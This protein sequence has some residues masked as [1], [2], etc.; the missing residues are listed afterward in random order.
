M[1]NNA[2]MKRRIVFA[3][4]SPDDYLSLTV[5]RC[6]YLLDLT[7]PTPEEN[8]ALEEA[9]LEWGEQ[10][11]AECLRL[12][13]SPVHFVVMGAG[14]PMKTDVNIAECER[15]GIPILRRCSGGG[16]V[17]QGP[18][19]FNY[20]L[21]LDREARGELGTIKS[22]NEE[23]LG[24][25]AEAL[26][27]CGVPGAKVQGTSDLTAGDLKFSGNSQR[28]RKRYLLF[29]GTVLYDFE[30]GMVSECL[31]SP[32]KMPEYREGRE[33]GRF[34]TNIPVDAERAKAEIAKVWGAA[35][36]LKDWPRERTEELARGR[37]ADQEWIRSI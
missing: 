15:R 6:M 26:S 24:K 16:T 18:G 30:L 31:G 36:V 8:L 32:E 22:S 37:Y 12:W 25:V 35:D 20:T 21:V 34:V 14:S 13:E 5:C 23:I 1:A 33:H 17:M 29:H 3:I 19:C 2:I 11:E 10:N 27:R 9:L 4:V 7:L 28:R